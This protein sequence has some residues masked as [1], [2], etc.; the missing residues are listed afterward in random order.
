MFFEKGAK[1]GGVNLW[2]H[3]GGDPEEVKRVIRSRIGIGGI[4]V[5]VRVTAGVVVWAPITRLGCGCLGAG[6]GEIRV[7]DEG[8]GTTLES[9]ASFDVTQVLDLT[10]DL[11]VRGLD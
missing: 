7:Y 10:L 1:L 5:R 3:V 2:V 9:R 11:V 6:G 4:F 8:A